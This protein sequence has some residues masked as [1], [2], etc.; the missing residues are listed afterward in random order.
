MENNNLK[1]IK[2]ETKDKIKGFHILMANNF[3]FYCL[4][5]NEYIVSDDALEELK[6]KKIGFKQSLK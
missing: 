2:I 6:K 5:N 3:S 1:R 4:P